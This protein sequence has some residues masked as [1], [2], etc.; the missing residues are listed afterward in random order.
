ME[1]LTE[2]LPK[3]SEEE[4]VFQKARRSSNSGFASV[5]IV[6]E[7]SVLYHFTKRFLD[8][9][10]SAFGILVLIPAF[11]IIAI[12][13][14][15]DDGGDVFHFREI[16]GQHGRRFFALKFRTMLP[17]ADAYLAQHPELLQQYQ[18]QMKLERDP[19]ITRV[20][21][22]L[23]K[24]S[25]DEL[26][27]LFNVLIGQMSLVG[28]RIIHPSELPRYGGWAQ[29]RLSVKP[30]ITGL[31]QISERQHICY[32]ERVL[33]DMRYI[34]HRSCSADLVILLKTMRVFII[35]TGA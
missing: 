24:A 25:L 34:D 21:R 35:H 10:L 12:C 11:L 28:P 7:P 27:Q 17:N 33:L 20:G 23:R 22:F 18:Q 8:V 30:G 32:E 9:V 19:R 13:I 5:S 2:F 3:R 31:W 15:L 29:K 16:I 6:R 4:L 1:P 26:P 14:K